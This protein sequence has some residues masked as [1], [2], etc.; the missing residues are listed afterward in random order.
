MKV[1]YVCPFAHYS[2]HHPH[3]SVVEPKYLQRAGVDVTL[4]TFNGIMNNPEIGVPQIKV[5]NDGYGALAIRMRSRTLP[6]WVMMF[7]ETV[8]TLRYAI[9]LYRKDN[10]DVIHLRDGE[11]FI[12]LSH[13]LSIPYNNINWF[14]SLTSAIIFTP[15]L[16]LNDWL[17]RPF[18][19]LYSLALNIVVNCSLWNILYRKSMKK[20][21]HIYTP[22]NT[23]ATRA[24]RKYLG[25]I[26]NGNVECIELGIGNSIKLPSKK[27]SRERLGV[28]QKGFVLLS[29]GAPN[30]G[31]DMTTMFKAVSETGDFLLH[32]GTHT[33][34][35]GSNPEELAKQYNM[36]D[37]TQIDNYYIPEEEKPYYFG[38]AD[39][40]ILSYTKAF[41]STS[42]MMWEAAR[43]QLPVISSNANSLGGDVKYYGLGLLFEAENSGSLV[44]KINEYKKLPKEKIAEFKNNCKK[45]VKEHSDEKWSEK[46]I[47]VYERLINE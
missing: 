36:E 34:S 6:R 32:G 20:N 39:A 5:K 12:F 27:E 38:A 31:K 29:F 40:I 11:P 25:G 41:A 9:N 3:V 17:N 28:P 13:L 42:S 18:V 19:C 21:K 15:K 43:Y 44:G 1:L 24:Y 33:F 14:V 2:G 46:C 45:F 26:F 8:A 23:V 37:R 35:L 10:Y 30:A 47:K 7:C 16:K 4:L 22:Q